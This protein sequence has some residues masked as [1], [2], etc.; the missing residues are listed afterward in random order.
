[1]E[2]DSGSVTAA[3]HGCSS[4]VG[5]DHASAG[6]LSSSMASRVLSASVAETTAFGNRAEASA[7]RMA[8]ELRGGV[9]VRSRFFERIKEPPELL[10]TGLVLACCATGAGVRPTVATGGDKVTVGVERVGARERR[11]F[12]GAQ[13]GIERL[14]SEG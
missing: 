2:L 3:F 8:A 6:A 9:V 13:V 14:V 4:A 5:D 1:M 10:T 12:G 7:C 11:H